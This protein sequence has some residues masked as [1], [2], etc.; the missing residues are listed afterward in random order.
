MVASIAF[1]LGIIIG[2]IAMRTL[3]MKRMLDKGYMGNLRIDNS[4][5]EGPYIFLELSKDVDELKK[6]KNVILS[7]IDKNYV[8]Q[9]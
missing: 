8:S 6:H 1:I 3:F 4:D 5:G 9:K 7:V 2:M